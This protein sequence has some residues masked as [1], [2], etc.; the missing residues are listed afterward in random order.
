[1][2]S[3]NTPLRMP[4]RILVI[5]AA[6]VPVVLSTAVGSVLVNEAQAFPG[7]VGEWAKLLLGAALLVFAAFALTVL[8]W[9]TRLL[10]RRPET[11]D[12][13]R[14]LELLNRLGKTLKRPSGVVAILAALA[15]I[16]PIARLLPNDGLE[17]GPLYIMSA[18]DESGA[19]NV[20]NILVKQ[21][22]QAH[23]D[24]PVK[25]LPGTDTE[26]DKQH[27]RMVKD[28]EEH[29]QADLYVLDVVYMQEFISNGYIRPLDESRRSPE[30]KADDFLKNVLDTCRDL[31]GDGKALWALPWNTDAGLL[32]RRSEGPRPESWTDYFP[33]SA[34]AAHLF[35]SESLTITALE[36]IWAHGGDVVN[37]DGQLVL[38]PD[39][40]AVDFDRNA[41]DALKD[42]ADVYKGKKPED[43]GDAE[44]EALQEFTSGKTGVMRNWPVAYDKLATPPNGLPSLEVARLPHASV[45]GGQN[46]AIAKSTSKPKAAQALIEFL[47]SP[48]SELI[49]FEVGGFAPTRTY[50]YTNATRP[51]REE[52]KNAVENARPRPITPHYTEFSRKFREGVLYAIGNKGLYPPDFPQTLARVATGG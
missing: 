30:A 20:R 15:L 31:S 17:P 10:L 32:Y 18:K 27:E 38:T 2:N 49:L 3:R 13:L 50:A 9:M 8:G 4:Y 37:A 45:L 46:L 26:P 52:L 12:E 19:A 34:N 43:E 5:I 48:S 22:N 35:R 1:M 21:W 29:H 14:F 25:F 33:R 6:I 23:P 51:Y 42:L 24:N 41:S 28:A 36:A 11:E 47:T 39:D 40:S 16:A 7:D 44:E